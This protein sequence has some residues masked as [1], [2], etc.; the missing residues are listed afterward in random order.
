[1][2]SPIYFIANL[3]LLVDGGGDDVLWAAQ[4]DD[5]L[6][7]GTGDDVLNGSSDND[8]LTGGSGSDIFEFT[9]TS[10]NDTITDF[11]KDEDLLHF[12][13]REGE[14]EETEVASINNGV[15]TW[16]AVTVDLGN[17]S[18]AIS[19]LNITYEMI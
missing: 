13:F 9:A 15:L 7:G 2:T 3:N 12:Y 8:I 4:G 10:G 18:L 1:M 14:A 6:N 19:D 17:T 5:T 16:D 11:D